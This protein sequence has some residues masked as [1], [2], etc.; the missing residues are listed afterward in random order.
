MAEEK[1]VSKET[2]IPEGEQQKN[3]TPDGNEVKVEKK[4]PVKDFFRKNSRKIK[5]G[6]GIA[7]AVGVGI[8]VDKLG[9]SKLGKKKTE[10]APEETE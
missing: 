2:T 1:N 3:A 10:E 4:H 6:L 9:L 8:A 7:G 5:T